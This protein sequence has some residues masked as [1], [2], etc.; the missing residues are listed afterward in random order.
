M[1]TF[2]LGNEIYSKNW[3]YI[4]AVISTWF[5]GIPPLYTICFSFLRFLFISGDYRVA[6]TPGL[7]AVHTLM[8]RFHNWVADQLYKLNY[9]WSDERLFQE[10]RRIVIAV[11][12]H[13]TYNEFLPNLL[14]KYEM[15]TWNLWV[16]PVSQSDRSCRTVVCVFSRDVLQ[17]IF[18]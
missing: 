11:I 1:H 12:Q 5:K 3:L 4:L 17:F 16:S 6:T 7:T 2:F 18:L 10:T 15:D 9:H 14:N 13:I 8:I